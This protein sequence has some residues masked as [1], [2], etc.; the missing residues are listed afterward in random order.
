MKFE[1]ENKNPNTININTIIN[2][3]STIWITKDTKLYT[4]EDI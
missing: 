3:N 1:K 4:K 2:T